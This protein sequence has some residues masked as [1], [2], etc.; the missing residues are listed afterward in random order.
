[1]PVALAR[2]KGKPVM[3]K[4]LNG[5]DNKHP[6]TAHRRYQLNARG[7]CG[8]WWFRSLARLIKHRHEALDFR[9]VVMYSGDFYVNVPP[10]TGKASKSCLGVRQEVREMIGQADPSSPAFDGEVGSPA[11]CRV[12]HLLAH[13]QQLRALELHLFGLESHVQG[14]ETTM[15]NW[16]AS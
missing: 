15:K 1:M 4:G 3:R 2:Q 11:R 14:W 8:R 5:E 13:S 9:F 10:T 16:D 6:C 12:L 7:A